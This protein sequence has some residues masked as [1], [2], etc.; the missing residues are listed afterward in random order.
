MPLTN[1]DKFAI[2][3]IIQKELEDCW[4]DFKM[5]FDALDNRLDAM[6]KWL[7]NELK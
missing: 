6:G 2:R 1:A 5:R 3:Q 4:T 7:K